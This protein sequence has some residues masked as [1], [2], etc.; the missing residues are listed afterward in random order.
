MMKFPFS[1][2]ESYNTIV[3]DVLLDGFDL[4]LMVDTVLHIQSLI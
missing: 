1:L 3:V 2:D 4:R